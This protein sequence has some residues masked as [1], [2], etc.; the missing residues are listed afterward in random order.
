MEQM[1]TSGA[2]VP[3]HKLLADSKERLII[4]NGRTAVRVVQQT[5]AMGSSKEQFAQPKSNLLT[6][7]CS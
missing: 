4:P 7:F 6:L 3:Q 1:G 5:R 2:L